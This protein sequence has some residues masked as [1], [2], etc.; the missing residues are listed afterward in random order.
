MV[1]YAEI[2]VNIMVDF[3]AEADIIVFACEK[4][5]FGFSILQIRMIGDYGFGS[6][7][8]WFFA[9]W[10]WSFIMDFFWWHFFD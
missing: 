2:V 1:S 6:Y 4:L 9:I 7:D 10:I 3:V 8:S 5:P